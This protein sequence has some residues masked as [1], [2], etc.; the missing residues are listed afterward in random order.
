MELSRKA[1]TPT[2]PRFTGVSDWIAQFTPTKTRKISP[3]SG[4][5]KHDGKYLYFAFD[6]TDDVLYGIDTERWLPE[7]NPRAHE[8]SRERIS[9]VWRR[10]GNPVNATNKWEGDENAVGNGVSWQMV[11]NL[12]KSQL[13]GTKVGGIIAGEP[14]S[15]SDAWNTYVRW[16][17]NGD[18]NMRR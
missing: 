17:E 2:R 9:M 18:S 1:N 12:T 7:N 3:S 4:Y 8:I 10:D 16:I 14:R 15:N 6:V 13:H 11:C 5:V